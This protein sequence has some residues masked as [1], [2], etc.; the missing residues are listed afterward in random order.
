MGSKIELSIQSLV[1]N[2][3]PIRAHSAEPAV[4]TSYIGN[5]PLPG[6]AWPGQGGK[7]AG[8]I[9]PPDGS[10]PYYVIATEH[11]DGQIAEIAWGGYG[12]DEPGAQSHWDGL[13]NTKALVASEHN[14]PAAQWADG[15]AIDGHS[16]FYLPA[17]RELALVEISLAALFPKGWHLT[18]TQYSPD[19]A[20][21]QTFADGGTCY[22]TK[23]YEVRALA[24]RRLFI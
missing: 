10:R 2:I 5:V 11:P 13:A 24:V 4:F 16:D 3:E 15:L 22:V 9:V 23:G 8:L 17:R 6:V 18:S 12:K 7:N 20:Y 21:G 14:H 19:N 1:I